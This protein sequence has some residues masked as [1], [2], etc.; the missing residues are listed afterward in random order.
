MPAL[1]AEQT[2]LILIGFTPFNPIALTDNRCG[3]YFRATRKLLDKGGE[4]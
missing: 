4:C 3:G 2:P 1:F